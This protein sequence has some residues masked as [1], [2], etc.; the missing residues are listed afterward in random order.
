MDPRRLF[1]GLCARSSFTPQ[2]E[3]AAA[4]REDLLLFDLPHIVKG[5]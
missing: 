2:V 5:V 4:Q 3:E 1:Y